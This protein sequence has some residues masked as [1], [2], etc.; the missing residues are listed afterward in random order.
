MA[1]EDDGFAV[2][3]PLQRYAIGDG[4]GN[5]SVHRVADGHEIVRLPRGDGPNRHLA[6][7]PDGRYLVAAYAV[8]RELLFDLWDISQR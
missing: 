8:R 5:V 7:S 4:E 2:D 1:H 3:A 6:F